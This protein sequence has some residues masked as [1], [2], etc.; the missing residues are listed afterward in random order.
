[1]RDA[2]ARAGAR[3]VFFSYRLVVERSYVKRAL[4][5]PEFE[6]QAADTFEVADHVWVLDI[7][8]SN[9]GSEIVRLAL[10]K[11][12]GELERFPGA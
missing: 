9:R 11:V 12:N 2:T 8:K 3:P 1:M 10:P 4:L 5:L 6:V 7:H